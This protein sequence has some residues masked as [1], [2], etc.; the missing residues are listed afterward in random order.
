NS[1]F[2][3]KRPYDEFIKV[4][5]KKLFPGLPESQLRTNELMPLAYKHVQNPDLIL[6]LELFSQAVELFS[7]RANERE[8][9]KNSSI[10]NFTIIL[11]L[12]LIILGYLFLS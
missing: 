3:N 7:Q 11:L 9:I 2:A 10:V 4:P 8:R 6:P 1:Q 12:I 5:I